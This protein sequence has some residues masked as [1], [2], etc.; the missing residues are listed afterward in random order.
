MDRWKEVR[1]KPRVI[2]ERGKGGRGGRDAFATLFTILNEKKVFREK[3]QEHKK[4]I[5][6]KLKSVI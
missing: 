4:E 3:F 5:G 2:K 1:N 6:F